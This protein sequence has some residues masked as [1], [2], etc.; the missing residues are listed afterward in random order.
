[1]AILIQTKKVDNNNKGER[2]VLEFL[3]NLPDDFIVI[4][5]LKIAK[6]L[7]KN[8]VLQKQPDFVVLSPHCGVCILE[9]KDWNLEYNT[10]E[11]KDQFKYIR[12][13]KSDGTTIEIENPFEKANQYLFSFKE[14]LEKYSI[15]CPIHSFAVFPSNSSNDFIQNICTSSPKSLND[16]F[17]FN[18]EQ[19]I[20]RNKFSQYYSAPEGFFTKEIPQISSFFY[21]IDNKIVQSVKNVLIPDYFKIGDVSA[22]IENRER[23]QTLSEKQESWVFSSNQKE[24]FLFDLPGSGKTNCLISKAMYLVE[25]SFE[26]IRILLTTYSENLKKNL[27]EIIKRK[28]LLLDSENSF[29]SCVDVRTLEEIYYLFVQKHFEKNDFMQLDNGNKKELIIE[30]IRKN[31]DSFRIYD[32]ALIDEVQDFDTEDLKFIQHLLKSDK[33]FFVGDIGQKLLNKTFDLRKLGLITEQISLPK[34]YKM[35]R[36]PENIAKL[37]YRFVHGSEIIRQEFAEHDYKA[38]F[39]CFGNHYYSSTEIERVNNF[40]DFL[41]VNIQKYLNLGYTPQ[42]IMV[43]CHKSILPELQSAVG[44]VENRFSVSEYKDDH[45]LLADFMHVKGLEKPV[46]IILGIDLLSDK[47]SSENLFKPQSEILNIDA[48]SR[49]LIYVALTRATERATVAYK[50]QTILISELLKINQAINQQ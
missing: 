48:H 45:L 2:Y 47:K 7:R 20:F 46:V 37:A 34:S 13:K 17:L 38:D 27:E 44:S 15:R 31:K 50:E 16:R 26:P 41:S 11:A 9:V 33:F 14:L 18:P 19:A 29:D 36:T 30:Q 49:K 23:V 3:E 8:V 28:T 10:Y 22:R 25:K 39:I 40:G 1:M 12:R 4:R 43:I 21:P 6:E 35:Y 32:Y 42:E 24:N 5:E